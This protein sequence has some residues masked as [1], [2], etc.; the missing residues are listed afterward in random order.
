MVLLVCAGLF[1]QSGRNGRR[2]RRRVPDGRRAAA[3]HRPA[4]HRATTRSRPA[5][6]YREIVDEVGALPGVR[7]ASWARRAPVSPGNSSGSVLTLDGGGRSRAGPRDRRRQPR[8]PRF[9]RDHRHSGD[10]RARIP[11]GGR[12][13]QPAG[14]GRQ[15]T[16]ST[17]VLAGKRT[18]SAAASS[19]RIR[20]GEPF[21]VIGVAR[22][23]HMSQSPFD[24]PPFVLYAVRGPPDGLGDPA[25]T[26][27][28]A[29]P[30][31]VG[32]DHRGRSPSRPDPGRPGFRHH[33]RRG[34]L[35]ADAG[36]R[37][38][39]RGRHRGLRDARPSACRGGALRRRVARGSPA[40]ARVRDPDRSRRVV[41]RDPPDSLSAGASCSRCSAWAPGRSPPS[42]RRGLTAGFPRRP[43]EPGDPVVFAVVGLLL[44]GAA[45]FACVVPARRAAKAD[46][47][48][49]LRGG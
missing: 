35:D 49:T 8:R 31:G 6:L 1:V 20:G 11:G 38:R 21:E 15:R 19:T 12:S 13:R 32:H 26:H 22:D 30:C 5:P 36:E 37:A 39:R 43:F 14:D 23:A 4:S 27:R 42:A 28:R 44:G 34:A 25:R 46:P 17:A 24:R 29:V 47:L 33:G 18:R 9:L 41:G 10:P 48:A 40:A 7:A 3:V 16:R 2:D 45:L